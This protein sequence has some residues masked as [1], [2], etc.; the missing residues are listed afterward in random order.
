VFC[1]D[2]TKREGE[3][4][5]LKAISKH[6]KVSSASAGLKTR[7]LGTALSDARCSIG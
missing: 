5:K 7:R 6:S 2:S 4:L 1:L 3:S